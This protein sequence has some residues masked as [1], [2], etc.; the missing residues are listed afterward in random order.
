MEASPFYL[1][2]AVGTAVMLI[3]AG[4]IVVFILF[5]QRR[6]LHEKLKQN[7][8]EID[9]QEKSLRLVLEG[10]ENERRRIAKDL[11]DGV[12]AMMQ[13]LR[14]SVL[15]VIRDA[16]EKDKKEIQ[17][18]V[19]E[20]TE[21]V[22]SVSWDLMPSTLEMFGLASALEEFCA[23]LNGKITV[24]VHFSHQGSPFALAND[25]QLLVYRITQEAVNNAIKHAKASLIEVRMNWDGGLHVAIADDGV[26]FDVA[27]SDGS[28]GLGLS[29]LESRARLLNADLKFLKNQPKGSVVELFL[30]N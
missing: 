14:V 17:E 20:L 19:S 23:R 11:H 29:N 4:S 10:Q 27:A 26:G 24:P 18:M 13:A 22:R 8:M 15:T 16:D 28:L 9:H 21:T 30:S 1:L 7:Q 3:M 2:L 25:Q 12:Q 5:Y 6:M